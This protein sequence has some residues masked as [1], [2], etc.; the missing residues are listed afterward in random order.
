MTRIAVTA[1]AS[2]RSG[3]AGRLA[4]VRISVL[5]TRTRR[6]QAWPQV[7]AAGE[8]R[9]RRLRISAA[10]R[11]T[12]GLDLDDHRRRLRLWPADQRRCWRGWLNVHPSLLLSLAGAPVEGDL[13]GDAETGV[14]ITN[15]E[16]LDRARS[17]LEVPDRRRTMRGVFERA[18]VV[19]RNSGAVLA[20]P[21]PSF[22]PQG[23]DGVT[24]P[25]RSRPQIACSISTPGVDHGRFVRCRL[26]GA[27][28]CTPAMHGGHA[29]GGGA[30]G[31]LGAAGRRQTDGR[32]SVASGAS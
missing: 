12:A 28:Q 26:I 21:S 9:R 13:A 11:P 22:V 29:W 23:A 20:A 1:T 14:T 10:A 4:A 15:R 2:V 27:R 6:A 7:A 3:C 5:L 25:T 8:G 17:P 16:G 18:A 32:R 24:Y 31:P 30:A 19:P